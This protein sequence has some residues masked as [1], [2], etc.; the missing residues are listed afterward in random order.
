MSVDI[1]DADSQAIENL[2]G[3]SIVCSKTNRPY[4]KTPKNGPYQVVACDELAGHIW[5]N[6]KQSVEQQGQPAE[7]PAV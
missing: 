6:S 4:L 1:D 5:R 2:E 3:I 7:V